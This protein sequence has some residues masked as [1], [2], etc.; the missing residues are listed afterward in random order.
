MS[1]GAVESAIRSSLAEGQVL[2][3]PTRPAP[4]VVV[5]IDSRGVTLLLG[6]GQSKPHLNWACLE[7]IPDY[8]KHHGGEIEIGG[9]HPTLGRPGTLD[10][11]LKRCS[12]TDTAGYVAVVFETAGVAQIIHDRPARIRMLQASE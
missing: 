9:R 10:G 3:T 8:V 12:T 11:Y 7:G 6:K 1:N 2:Y 5:G 4:F